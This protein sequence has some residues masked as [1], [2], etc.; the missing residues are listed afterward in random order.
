MSIL[1]AFSG[2]LDTSFCVP[3]LKETYGVPIHTVTVDTGGLQPGD[4]DAIASRAGELGAASHTLVDGKA[5]LFDRHLRYLIYGNVQ[6]GGVYPLCVGPERVV[7]A[8]ALV[9]AAKEL[10]ATAIAHGSTGAG[11]D[12]VRF[13]VAIQI[14]SRK[15]LGEEIDVLA[16]VRALGLSREASTSYLTG[17]G[18]EVPEETT[19]Y[20]IN[21]GLWGTT[22]GGAE[23]LTTHQPLSEDAY[24]DTV[25]PT[26]AP[27]EPQTVELIFEKGVPVSVDDDTLDPV[28]LVDHLNATGG[29]HGVGRGIHVGDTILGIKGRVGFEAPAAEILVTA[30]RELEKLVLSK[31]QQV[32][33]Q[34]LASVYG[35]LLHEA[36]YFDPVMRDIEAFLDSTQSRV[37]GT[38]RVQLFKG[39]AQVLGAESPHSL[40]NASMATYGEENALWDGRDAEGFTRLAGIQSLLAA[41]AATPASPDSKA[42]AA[43]SASGDGARDG[44]RDGAGDGAPVAGSAPDSVSL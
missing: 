25:P 9:Q 28:A 44:A 31:W 36:Q 20:S 8:R 2:G 32:H 33:K 15:L 38:V 13:D 17:H 24:P 26:E 18:F 29:A 12:Q 35:M 4:A 6:R 30:H 42:F 37:T 23:T 7:Q 11:N 34:Q 1:L 21:R 14:L 40:F 27:D 3:Y 5:E 22:V 10:G 39:T 16:P 43:P 41:E 19:S